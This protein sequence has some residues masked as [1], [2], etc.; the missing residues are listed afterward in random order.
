M[1]VERVTLCEVLLHLS[2]CHDAVALWVDVY[3]YDVALAFLHTLFLLAERAE[4]I[5]HQAPVEECAVLVHPRHFEVGEVAHLTQ[6]CLCRC[7]WSL[8][9]VEV[10][11][12]V[13][14]VARLCAFGHIAFRHEYFSF[15]A[16][17]EVD[18]EVH[19]L[20]DGHFIVV[21]EFYHIVLL[22]VWLLVS[23]M[24]HLYLS[25]L[26]VYCAVGDRGEVFVVCD[27]DERLSELVAQVE[28]ELVQLCLVL[29]VER[30]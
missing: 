22:F 21:A 28:E 16:A 19:L 8:V 30:A 2:R 24:L 27:D 6:R 4:E 25:V 14:F 13:E 29:R 9:L 26:N 1:V 20:H 15:V 11:E 3:M 23:L 17:V 10:D 18:T 12:H 5:L 7:H